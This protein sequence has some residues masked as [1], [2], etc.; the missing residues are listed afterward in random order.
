MPKALRVQGEGRQQGLHLKDETLVRDDLNKNNQRSKWGRDGY[1]IE[2]VV[3]RNPEIDA[4]NKATLLTSQ[5]LIERKR[6]ERGRFPSR[7]RNDS[8]DHNPGANS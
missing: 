4:Q 1:E 6:L 2:V 7:Q 5:G 8:I 3:E